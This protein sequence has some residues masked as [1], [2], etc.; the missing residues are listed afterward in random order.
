MQRSRKLIYYARLVGQM[1]LLACTHPNYSH[2]VPC[3][4]WAAVNSP[5]F[6]WAPHICLYSRALV[7]VS[8]QGPMWQRD[9]EGSVQPWA[10]FQ[11]RTG[12]GAELKQ[13][14]CHV[15][16]WWPTAAR[17]ASAS[18]LTSLPAACG[19][20]ALLDDAL[21]LASGR[22]LFLP[23]CSPL[24]GSGFAAADCEKASAFSTLCIRHLKAF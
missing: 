5:G 16:L 11:Q 12:T 1:K 10:S 8:S 3:P 4:R 24:E 22:W 21:P 18:R 19:G 2:L 9:A 20:A 7:C 23:L 17:A 13:L 6:R 15:A 14:S